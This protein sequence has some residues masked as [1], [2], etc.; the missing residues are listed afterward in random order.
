MSKNSKIRKF[1][2]YPKD[3][4]RGNLSNSTFKEFSVAREKFSWYKIKKAGYKVIQ[5]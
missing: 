5:C 2:V 3:R 1:I 4:I